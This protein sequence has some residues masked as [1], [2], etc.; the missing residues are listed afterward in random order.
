MASWLY[1]AMCT[2]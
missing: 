1:R 2:T